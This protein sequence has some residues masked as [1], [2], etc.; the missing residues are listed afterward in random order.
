M[1]PLK[2]QRNTKTAEG[3]RPWA[4]LERFGWALALVACLPSLVPTLTPGWFEGHDDLH[5]YRLIEYDL[6][7]ADGQIPPRWFPDISAGFGNPHPIYYAPLFYIAAEVLHLGGFDI[8][9]SLKGSIVLFMLAAAA[10]MYRLARPSFGAAAAVV[11][12][13]AYT[14]A[15][16]HLLD[17]YVRKAFSEL[18]VFAVLPYLLLATRG[19]VLRGGRWNAIALALSLAT[20]CIAHTITTMMVPALVSAYALWLV[21]GDTERPLTARA[22]RLAWAAAAAA[23][24][25]ALAGFF[26][27]PAFLERNSI[28]LAIYTEAY[29]QYQKHFVF[30]QQLLW[31]PWGFGMSLDG[32]ADKMSFRMGLLQI[33]GA[34]LAAA[35]VTRLHRRAPGARREVI[36]W[37]WVTGAA[38]FMMLPISSPVWGAI[39]ALK[40]VQFPWRFLTVTTLST[41]LLCGAAVAAWGPPAGVGTSD[42][43]RRRVGGWAFALCAL[44]A[45]AAALG[46]TLGVNLRVP[47]ERVGF[48]EKPYNNMIDR[49]AG[50]PPEAFDA[51]FVR[52]HTLRWIDH[53]PPNVSFMARTPRDLERPRVEVSRGAAQIAMSEERTWR[54]RFAVEADTAARL[55]LNIYRF[56]GWVVRVDGAVTEVQEPAGEDQV[57][58]VD[59]APG[60]H[61]IV[62]TF[63][64]TGPRRLGDWLTLAGIALVAAIGLWPMKREHP[65]ARP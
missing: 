1:K 21:A 54:W 39:P 34:L 40:F 51:A 60:T 11:A 26:L 14:F 42:A 50:A 2:P 16:Y 32:L 31:W 15:P 53:L 57:I 49:G 61:E 17:L 55:R 43:P 36:F 6:A 8:I 18:T 22:A 23:A 46:G 5:I 28:N 44:F 65:E 47:V 9:D 12:S 52:R 38:I 64:T 19:M 25:G 3:R 30:P 10:G 13:A 7:L 35:G 59:V 27:V 56:P 20:T 37:L 41:S 63:E 45:V 33:A 48:E 4:H 24:G 58:F 62:A 29:V